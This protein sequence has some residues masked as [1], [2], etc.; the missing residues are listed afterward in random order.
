MARI[1]FEG[2]SA[3]EAEEFVAAIRGIALKE[4]KHK[5]HEWIAFFASSCFVGLALRWFEDLDFEMR[6]DWDLLRQA[7]LRKW[8]AEDDTNATLVPSAPAAAAPPHEQLAPDNSQPSSHSRPFLDKGDKYRKKARLASKESHRKETLHHRFIKNAKPTRALPVMNGG[9]LER[10]LR[11]PAGKMMRR[12]PVGE[13]RT[14]RPPV[15]KLVRGGTGASRGLDMPGASWEGDAP[16][17]SRRGGQ[18]EASWEVDPLASWGEDVPAAGREAGEG[19]ASW[20]N[21]G[22][23]TIWGGGEPGGSRKTLGG[24]RVRRAGGSTKQSWAPTAKGL[25]RRVRD[26]E[27]SS[28]EEL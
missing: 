26:P 13:E 24:S 6:C 9:H 23:A 17:S 19:R 21:D 15:G 22:A 3:K 8:P 10:H 20:E 14:Y 2:K 16:A 27:D 4:G 18:R 1:R 25:K 28:S 7:I 12:Q 11:G 5:D